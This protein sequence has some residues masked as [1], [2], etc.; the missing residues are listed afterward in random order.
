MKDL[1]IIKLKNYFSI[2]K[3]ASEL[4]ISKPAVMKALRNN[5]I[6]VYDAGD[7]SYLIHVKDFKKLKQRREEQ[8][9]TDGRIKIF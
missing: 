7:N 5:N 6:S 9:K 4:K 2:K 1:K 8:V 3:A